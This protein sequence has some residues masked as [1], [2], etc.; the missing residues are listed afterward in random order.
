MKITEF[1]LV[2]QRKTALR[3]DIWAYYYDIHWY[4]VKESN[5]YVMNAMS[6]WCHYHLL[7]SDICVM[8][9]YVYEETMHADY[10]ECWTSENFDGPNVRTTS[11]R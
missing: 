4:S 5:R 9:I 3:V 7:L 8:F 2:S 10:A 1:S 6:I 11:W